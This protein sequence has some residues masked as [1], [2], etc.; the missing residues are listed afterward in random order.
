MAKPRPNLAGALD[1]L[2]SDPAPSQ[3]MDV[4]ARRRRLS[5][6]PAEATVLVG[7]NLPPRYAR[8]LAMLHAETGR[9]KKEL[10]QEALDML[11]TAKASANIRQ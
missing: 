3:I 6:Q 8:N 10:M 5:A 4:P 7:A 1:G 2:P 11:F 9:S